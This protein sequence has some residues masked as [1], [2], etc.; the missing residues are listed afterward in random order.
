MKISAAF[1]PA[2]LGLAAALAC[3]AQAQGLPPDAALL[4]GL[5]APADS[6]GHPM[7]CLIEPFQVSELGSPSAG[8]LN[9]VLVQ[10]GDEVR[11]GRWWP[12]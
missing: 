5:G 6:L 10:R 8:V 3:A 1:R 7:A 9:K 4:T 11:K 12:S 2:C